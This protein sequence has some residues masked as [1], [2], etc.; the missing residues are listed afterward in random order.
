MKKALLTLLAVIVT[1]GVLAG[2][3]FVGYRIGY[4][5]GAAAFGNILFDGHPT[6]MTPDL[7]HRFDRDLGPSLDLFRH[8]MMGRG[9]IG[10]N[11]FYPLRFLWNIAVLALVVW[12]G[13]W[14]FTKSGLR[15]T[16]QAVKDQEIP[17]AQKEG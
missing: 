2:A 8:P 16:R 17:P 13:Y 15:I 3:G 5:Q 14:L 10:F 7:M 11:I 4:N 9:D 6:W 1:L 12:F